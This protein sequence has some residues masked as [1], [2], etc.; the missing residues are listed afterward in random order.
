MTTN[1]LDKTRLNEPM[2]YNRCGA[3]GL[4]LPALSLGGWHHFS[5]RELA[6][7]LMVHAFE[8]GI[9]H[10]DLA[11]NYGI[12]PGS[13]QASVGDVLKSDLAAHRDEIIVSSK[14]GYEQLDDNLAALQDA[15]LSEDELR[16]IEAIVN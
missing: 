14:A 15:P 6:R 2:R 10:F 12:S 8:R 11:N 4:K 9:T 13:A 5:D 1:N 7:R 3:S 16:R